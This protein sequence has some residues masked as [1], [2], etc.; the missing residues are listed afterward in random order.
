MGFEDIKSAAK[1]GDADAQYR[2]AMMY[3]NNEE[4]SDE[5][6]KIVEAGTGVMPDYYWLTSTWFIK[7]AEQ[8]HVEAQY[9]LGMMFYEGNRV[10]KD[11]EA[12][13]LQ[14][15]K[16]AERGHPGAIKMLKSLGVNYSAKTIEEEQAEEL[17]RLQEAAQQGDA[18]SQ[19]ELAHLYARGKYGLVQDKNHAYVLFKKAADQG[20]EP[21]EKYAYD[22][23]WAY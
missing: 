21:A 19:Y 9:M 8:G 16:A 11:E 18:K 13:A 6:K 22:I 15:R 3:L 10:G 7:A 5:D 12:A 20:Y 4:V 14:F 2:L 1:Q 23:G 17:Q